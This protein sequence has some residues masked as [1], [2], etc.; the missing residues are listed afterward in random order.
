MKCQ[1]T[2]RLLANSMTQARIHYSL[3]LI[4]KINEKCRY[5]W[6]TILSKDA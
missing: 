4:E 2:E 5:D 6:E 1:Y 3:H